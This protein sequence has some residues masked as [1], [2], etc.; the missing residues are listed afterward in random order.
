MYSTCHTRR[1]LQRASMTKAVPSHNTTLHSKKSIFKFNNSHTQNAEA[2][3]EDY[4]PQRS[5]HLNKLKRKKEEEKTVPVVGRV[6]VQSQGIDVSRAQGNF[7]VMA[8]VGAQ[9]FSRMSL[10]AV[11]FILVLCLPPG[12]G[13]KKKEVSPGTSAHSLCP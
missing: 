12:G 3:V 1:R 13:Q 11:L 7:F 10:L 5:W 8:S 4:N 2:A 9:F 6:S